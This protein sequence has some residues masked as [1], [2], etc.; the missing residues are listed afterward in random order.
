M[1]VFCYFVEPA[2]YTLD[3]SKNIYDKNEIDYCFIKS[4]TLVHSSDKSEKVFLDIKSW[5]AK[6]TYVL[7]CFKEH[8]FIIVNGYNNYPFVLTFLFNIFAWNKRY[9][10]TDSDTQLSISKNP[11]KRS[12][13]WLYLSLIFQNK[14]VLG[15]AGGS[16]FHKDLF[17]YYGMNE[18]RIFLMPMMVDN[19]KFL[20]KNRLN[21]DVFTFL[22]VGRLVEDKNVE[23]LIQEFSAN[24]SD[25]NAI[26][27]IVGDG[28]EKEYLSYKYTSEKIVFTGKKFNQDLIDLFHSSSCFVCPSN[29]EPW[30]LVVNEALSAGL[31]VIATSQVGAHFD[32]IKGKETGFIAED[33]QVF[34]EMMLTLFN[35]TKLLDRYS[36][37]ANELMLNN[38][39]YDLYNNCLHDAINKVE[40]WR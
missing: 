11:I 17:R 5:F 19:T 31:P 23:A 22:F 33:M 15:F 14:Y 38:W 16:K 39:N 27:K 37:N 8:D 12:V 25:K 7:N 24:F 4:N 35:D 13:K 26:L 36:K 10:A 18:N 40:Q 29:F 2:S 1:K 6:F 32:L 28:E 30:G 20:N 21:P 3:L 9:I 34:G